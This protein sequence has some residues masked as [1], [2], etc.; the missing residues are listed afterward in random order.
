VAPFAGTDGHVGLAGAEQLVIE[1]ALMPVRSAP[2]DTKGESDLDLLAK[3]RAGDRSAF[4]R[5]YLL[6]HPRL[7]RFLW[8]LIRRPALVEEVLDDT[9]MVVWQTA[10]N[11]R[12]SS[13]LSTWI[14]AIAYR[15]ATKARARWP[16][17]LEDDKSDGRASDEPTPEQQIRHHRLHD[18]IIEAMDGLSAEHRAVVDLTYFHG[19]G[20]REIAQIVNC[21]VDTV[22]TRMFHARRRLRRAFAGSFQD[23]L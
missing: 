4:E 10:V 3:V 16:D 18:A 20:Y 1:E 14:F 21:P 2:E 17:P 15:K 9:M 5:L 6:Y 19:L 22:K 12:G 11:F 7:T 8:T 13:K 23:W